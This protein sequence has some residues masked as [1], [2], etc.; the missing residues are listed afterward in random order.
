[1]HRND[2]TFYSSMYRFHACNHP[3]LTEALIG[4]TCEMMGGHVV[5]RKIG[6]II[7]NLSS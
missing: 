3:T 6:A 1:M 2:G 5:R 7:A 4:K